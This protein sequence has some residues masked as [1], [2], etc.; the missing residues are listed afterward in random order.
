MCNENFK[1]VYKPDR[2]ISLD[3]GC[4][5]WKGRLRFRCYNPSKPAKFHIKLF[6]ISESTS[7]YV[8]GFDIYTGKGSCVDEAYPYQNATCNVTTKTVLTLSARSDVLDKGHHMYFDNYYTSP[9]LMEELL[10]RQTLSCG[11][12]RKDRI[13]LPLALKNINLKSGEAVFLRKYVD[14]ETPGPMFAIRWCDKRMVYM[15]STM[16]CGVEVWTGKKSYKDQTPI[17]KPECIVDYTNKMGGVDMSDQLMNYY[18]FLRKSI[19]WWRKLFIHLLNMLIMNAFILNKKFGHKKL[20][21]VAYREYLAEYLL[22]DAITTPAIPVNEQSANEVI[23]SRLTGHHFPE[24]LPTKEDNDKVKPL[25]C[26]VC[27]VGKLMSKT[28]NLPPRRKMCSYRCHTCKIP[29]CITPC[30]RIYH[31]HEDYLSVLTELHS[32]C[33]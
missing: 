10:H 25:S 11:T 7:G 15:L 16:H 31:E 29:M 28:S 33:N 20:S 26:K 8:L 9:Q 22:K 3:E 32:K 14:V 23:S 30:F 4:C 17:Y 27:F 6:Q 12:T 18:H 2:D 5:P 1:Y 24:Y 19:K 13:G 21:H